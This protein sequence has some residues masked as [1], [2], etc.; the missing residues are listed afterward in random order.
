[1]KRGPGGWWFRPDDDHVRY[2]TNHSLPVVVV[3]YRPET[4][5]CYWKLVNESTLTKSSQGG[6]KVLVPEDHVLDESAEAPL[7]ERPLKAIPTF[8]VSE[9][10]NCRGRG[11]NCWTADSG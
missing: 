8:S 4:D 10:C 5:R 6:W 2:W 11:W 1:M 7:R 3:L 9:S